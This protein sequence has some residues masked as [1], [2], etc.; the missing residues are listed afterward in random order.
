MLYLIKLQGKDQTLL[1]IGHTKDLKQRIKTYKTYNP[2]MELLDTQEGES[3]D[4]SII[5]KRL[6][7]YS[8]EGS[9]EWFIEDDNVYKIWNN[10]KLESNEKNIL[11]IKVFK[12]IYDIAKLINPKNVEYIRSY[13]GDCDKFPKEVFFKYF[14]KNKLNITLKQYKNCIEILIK[15]N[16]L[17]PIGDNL[18]I[19]NPEIIKIIEKITI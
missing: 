18:Y 1:K 9:N 6:Q 4:E 19:L 16:Y 12:I 11:N 3:K 2:L 10:Y 7:N 17:I 8:Y 15:D 13:L 14:I 5:H